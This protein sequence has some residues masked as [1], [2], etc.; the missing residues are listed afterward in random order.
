[1]NDL[2]Y[3]EYEIIQNDEVAPQTHLLKIRGHIPFKPGQ[4][5]QAALD[6]F[7]EATFA[8]CSDPSLK[9]YF[10]LSVRGVGNTSNAII[11]L[12]PGDKIKIRGPY[13]NGWPIKKLWW[14]DVVLIAGGMGLVPI[15]PVI[16]E[17]LRD[18]VNFDKISL[19]TGFKTPEHV[20][21][22]ED[23][24]QWSKKIEVEVFAELAPENFWG[25][26]GMITD[27][28]KNHKFNPAK[29]AVLMCGPDIMAKFCNE[30]LFEKGVKSKQIYVSME[31]R[32]ECGIGVCQHCSCGKYLVCKD[33]PVFRFDEIEKEIG[34]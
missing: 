24:Q 27:P 11:K 9:D 3:K 15:R 16:Y 21:F 10:E 19:F 1:M 34:K 23:L 14:K 8:I 25:K 31:R 4:F 13:G 29:T 33:G 2:S 17:L 20:L 26:K 7:G 32:M 28:L 5:I 30:V 18:R 6:H 12:L 22:A